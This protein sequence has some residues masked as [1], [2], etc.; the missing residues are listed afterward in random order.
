MERFNR[1]IVCV[2]FSFGSD[3]LNILWPLASCV[4]TNTDKQKPKHKQQ[5]IQSQQTNLSFHLFLWTANAFFF[6]WWMCDFQS[7]CIYVSVV[8][9]SG[10]IRS[11]K[12]SMSNY[13][14]HYVRPFHMRPYGDRP[15]SL[16]K[17]IF[18][19][20]NCINLFWTRSDFFKLHLS[21]SRVWFSA[22]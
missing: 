1:H 2:V 14:L 20:K 5:R 8:F 7:V 12:D 17:W 3:L 10:S 4:W 6:M 15:I 19:C 21:F 9:F 22:Q 16:K 13:I 11:R 18:E